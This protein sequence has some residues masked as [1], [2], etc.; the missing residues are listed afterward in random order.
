[1]PVTKSSNLFVPEIF[2]QHIRAG[3]AGMKVMRD[4]GAAVFRTGMSAGSDQVGTTIKIPYFNHIGELDDVAEGDALTPTL[5]S[6]SV[7]NATVQHSGKA[8][9]IT[10]WAT[11]QPSDPYAEATRQMVDA[12]ARR[13]DKALID[14]AMSTTSWSSYT[15]DVYSASTPVTMSYDLL[16]DAKFL[17]GDE[18]DDIAALVVHSLTARDMYKVK[19][20]V[21]RPLLVEGPAGTL[22]RLQPLGIP[23]FITDRATVSGSA[24]FSAILKRNSL[25]FWLNENP[26]IDEDKDILSD[27][28]VAAT[29]IYWAA[30]RYLRLNG[31]AKPG[32]V[33]IKHNVQA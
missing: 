7:E 8:F 23:V 10:K 17:F 32:V 9:E 19:D 30:H 11:S 16:V 14:A 28:K 25:I 2:E 15:K 29:H 21:G 3:I 31:M 22:P 5:L 4:T 24:Y 12:V 33:L 6:D 1:M 13:A 20:A 18:Q 27:S 26:S